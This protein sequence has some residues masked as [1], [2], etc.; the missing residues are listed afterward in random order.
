M[1]FNAAMQVNC[2]EKRSFQEV[3]FFLKEGYIARESYNHHDDRILRDEY[4]REVYEL[5]LRIVKEHNLFSIIDVGC[6]SGYKLMKYF[7]DFDTTGY[8]IEPTLSYLKNRYPER[9]WEESR[10]EEES[11]IPSA[12]L[13]ICAD[14]IEHLL[15][16]DEL[17]NFID[18][19][20]FK[21]V[22]ISTPDRDLLPQIQGSF[23]SQIGP[24]VNETH[25]REWSF[26]EFKR[27]A[28]EYFTIILHEHLQSE[29]WG[30]IIVAVKK[31]K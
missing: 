20:D 11:D 26:A 28:S 8:E 7:H 19:M 5:A 24:P 9:Q 25:I 27:Y 1:F 3:H 12:D 30:Q 16:P 13:V 22:V 2:L 4:Q 31:D 21:Y 6:G 29:F 23:Q 17:L 15:N 10:L 18:Q 14:V